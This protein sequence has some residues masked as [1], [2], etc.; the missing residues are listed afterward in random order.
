MAD[1]ISVNMRITLALYLYLLFAY[2]DKERSKDMVP[3]SL[4]DVSNSHNLYHLLSFYLSS[5]LVNLLLLRFEECDMTR[6]HLLFRALIF[7]FSEISKHSLIDYVANHN[8]KYSFGQL[9]DVL[10]LICGYFF[11]AWLLFS[12]QMSQDILVGKGGIDKVPLQEHKSEF[13]CLRDF[14]IS[15]ILYILHEFTKVLTLHCYFRLTLILSLQNLKQR[16][17]SIPLHFY[18][19]HHL[20]EAKKQNPIS[21]LFYLPIEL[22]EHFGDLEVANALIDE[23][24][25][26]RHF[27]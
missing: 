2:P 4:Q 17:H 13:D 19:T 24:I 20:F 12:S 18:L 14:S 27:F 3:L 10:F 5:M 21:F 11:L 22:G 16:S 9:E 6:V 1:R 7:D 25:R 26:G 23:L 8:A 15:L